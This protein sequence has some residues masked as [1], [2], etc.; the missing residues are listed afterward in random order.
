MFAIVQYMMI[1]GFP[2]QAIPPPKPGPPARLDSIVQLAIVGALLPQ[3]IPAPTPPVI[4]ASA[5]LFAMMQSKIV[6]LLESIHKIPPPDPYGI[7]L[8]YSGAVLFPSLK[9]HHSAVLLIMAHEVMW[10]E[11]REQAIPPPPTDVLFIIVQFEMVGE[12]WEQKIPP[13]P[14][15][16]LP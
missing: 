9:S 13:P 12:L 4:M 2:L 14:S 6:A 8:P 3:Q 1:G 16:E 10:G 5:R 7:C 11:L 15:A